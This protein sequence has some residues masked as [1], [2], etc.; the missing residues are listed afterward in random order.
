MHNVNRNQLGFSLNKISE[1]MPGGFLVYRDNEMLEI[2]F[3]NKKLMNIYE[4]ETLEEFRE[5]TGNSFR[6]CVLPSDWE[7]VQSTINEQVDVSD[8]YDYVQYRARTAK[9]KIIM[10]EDFGRIVHSDDDGDIFY[11]FIIDL[12]NKEK[13]YQNVIQTKG[14]N[15]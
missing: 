4:C 12:E 7:L 1:G 14:F 10:I 2:L 15:K 9:G 8:G 6:G 11:V 13:I 3:A 5:F